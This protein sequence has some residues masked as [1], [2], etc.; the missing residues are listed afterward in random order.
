[1]ARAVGPRIAAQCTLLPRPKRKPSLIA[2]TRTRA[3]APAMQRE[4]QATVFATDTDATCAHCGLP[5]PAAGGAPAR[6]CCQGCA[7]VHALLTEHGLTRFYDLGG[8]KGC[9]VGAPPVPQR[10]DWLAELEHDL[11]DGRTRLVLDVQGI[12]C[13]A[14]VFVLQELWRR[15]GGA[16]P[17][18]IN[19][20]IGQAE[21]CYRRDRMALARFLDTV[22][23]LGYRVAPPR[24]QA[25]AAD[26]GLLVRTGV[27]VALAMN[28]MMFA[29]TEY[30]GLREGPAFD[31]FRGVSFALATVAVMVGGPVFFRAAWAG[32]RRR[33]LHLDLPIALGIAVA[34]SGSTVTHLS[35]SGEPY[36]DTVTI[37][38]ALMLV[39]RYLQQRAI[40]RNRDYLLADDGLEHVRVRRVR[41]GA[42]ELVP[43]QAIAPG[44]V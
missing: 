39:G 1:M 33:V 19:P 8:G 44:D 36:F 11:G 2:V 42:L 15:H 9:P 31:L 20:A 37:F 40:Q 35:G 17:I 3:A 4:Q 38:V 6:F 43:A 34:W 18:R 30:F 12:H 7:A 25:A 23:R 21:L 5:V 29:S 32:L 27:C 41:R 10:R 14:C 13:A 28:A 22:E 24:K 26:R 16:V